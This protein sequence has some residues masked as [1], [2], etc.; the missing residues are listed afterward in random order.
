MAPSPTGFLH[1]GNVRTALFNWLFARHEGGEFLLRIEN[2]DTG[3]EVAEADRADPELAALARAR[4]GR[5]R[6]VPARP[7][8][9]LP[10]GGAPARRRGRGVRGRRRRSLPHARRGRDGLGRPRA[11]ADRGAERDDRGPRHPPLG[12][13]PDVQLRV[14]GRGLAGRDHARH[15]RPGPRAEHAEADPDPHGARR[16]AAAVRTRPVRPRRR[17]G[18]ALEAARVGD[19][20][21]VPRQGLPARRARQLPR[22]ARLELR[23]QDDDHVARRA[24]RALLARARVEEPGRL[25]LREARRG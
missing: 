9:A 13:P 16:R 3:R 19:D 12:R 14:T 11:R 17:R 7:A 2:T 1:V 24:R 20:R 10:G 22:A 25:R 21:R 6:D 5:R 4:M 15:P 18:G 23:R 8:R